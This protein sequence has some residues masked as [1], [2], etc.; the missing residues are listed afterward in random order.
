MTEDCQHLPGAQL[1]M[2]DAAEVPYQ[3]TS[4]C[5]ARAAST[6]RDDI[7]VSSRVRNDLAK[8]HGD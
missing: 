3:I 6:P 7:G 5:A 4:R 8:G 1:A 2:I